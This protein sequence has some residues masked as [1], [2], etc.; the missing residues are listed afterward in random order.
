MLC[1]AAHHASRSHHP[2]NPYFVRLCARRGDK[3]AVVAVAHRLCRIIFARLRHESDFD[4]GKLGVERGP[5][6]RTVVRAYRLKPTAVA[7]T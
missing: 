1:E 2:L 4:V 6:E 7:S 3:M 5:F